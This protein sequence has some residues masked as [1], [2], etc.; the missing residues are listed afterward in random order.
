MNKNNILNHTPMIQQYLSLKSKYPDIFLFYRLGDFYELF[1]DDAKKISCLLNI[2][3]TKR[4]YSLGKKVPM[5][6]IPYL[7]LNYYLSKLIKIGKSAVI[8]EQTDILNKESGLIERKISR[9]V[10][11]G[12]TIDECFLDNFKNNLL[13]A[14]YYSKKQFG[15]SVLDLCSGDFYVSVHNTFEDLLSELKC[16]DPEELLI[17]ENF[18]YVNYFKN[19]KGVKLCSSHYFEVN[20]SYRQLNLQFGTINLK[21]FGIENNNLVISVAG[22]LLKYLKS[23]RYF[24]LPHIKL[25]QMRHNHDYVFMNTATQRNLEII[26]NISGGYDNTL[27][28][29]LNHTSTAMGSRM[30][31]KWLSFPVRNINLIHDR[32][33]KIKFL[34]T[35][36]MI[37]SPIL[38]KVGD[39]ERIVS[40]IALRLASPKDFLSMRI[41]L[42]QFSKIVTVLKNF[43][44]DNFKILSLKEFKII[45]E[46]LFRAIKS[47]P[48]LT[49]KEG[50]VISDNYNDNLDKWRTIEKSAE[51]YLQEFESKEK[52]LLGIK[53]LKINKNKVLGY[54]LQISK[55]YTKSIPKKYN[56]IQTLKYYV[57]YSHPE[58]IEYENN[59]IRA[60]EK[61]LEIE[62]FL[63]DQLFDLIIP[64]LD[65]LRKSILVIS[66]LD[67]LNNL[68]ERSCVLNYVCPKISS[69][70]TLSIIGGRHPVIETLLLTPFIS[71]SINLSKKSNMLIIT[72]PNMGGK[73]TYMRQIAL[74]V[75]MTHIGSFVPASY[76]CI[77][78][79]DKIFTRI[80][81]SDNLASGESTFML[82]M[83]ETA[84]ILNNATSHSLVLIDELGRGTSMHD[85]LSLAWAC[86]EYLAQKINSMTLFSTHYF[87]LTKLEHHFFNIKNV[88]FD[89]VEYEDKVSFMYTLKFGSINKSYGLF[90]AKLAK[91]PSCVLLS[92]KKK[93]NKLLL[94]R[95]N[96][97]S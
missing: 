42:S 41:S 71:N 51:K 24:S 94:E 63:Y 21:S 22:C 3:L 23:I 59:F 40:R 87:E 55:K 30:L 54:Y 26:K 17:P 10:T 49:I 88:Y 64:H 14:I 47:S 53:S 16:T 8:C 13:S 68:A 74:I 70:Y 31:K 81:A 27:F 66:K 11:P 95:I 96:K 35:I 7:S 48:S 9:V 46:L 61:S 28:S 29:V 58:L 15:Y 25:I 90:V 72:G 75:I 50:N 20:S 57:R 52:K 5:A 89:V 4:G 67:V 73:S 37:L 83:S 78:I 18:L 93:L 62:K 60:K 86:I 6:G 84:S 45:Q 85:G 80:G 56:K 91:I 43:K 65:I 82:E 92:A 69:E 1:F 36:Y 12:T 39:L 33:N 76:A 97:I 34:R 19:R 77:K 44:L 79:F 2:T 32:Q 38:K